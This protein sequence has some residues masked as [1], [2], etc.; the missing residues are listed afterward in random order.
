MSITTKGEKESERRRFRAVCGKRVLVLV[1]IGIVSFCAA[2]LLGQQKVPA[3]ELQVRA[4][5]YVPPSLFS[6][7]TETRL[8]EVGA[9]VRDGRNHSI[10]GLTRDDFEI[11]EGGKKREITAF[12]AEVST[13][14]AAAPGKITPGVAPASAEAAPKSP[15]RFLALLFDDLS[16]KPG[17]L[18]PARKAAR[19]FLAQGISAGDQVSIFALSKGQTLPFTA[20]VQKLEDA[21]DKVNIATRSPILPTCPNLTTYD[22]YVVSERQD[23]SLLPIKVAEARQC[24]FCQPRDTGCPQRVEQECHRIW[25]EVRQMSFNTLASIRSVVDYMAKL[26]GK[27]ILLM[28]SSGFL[29]GTLEAEREEIVNRALRGEVVINSL[30]AKGLY[31]Q[32]MGVSSPGMNSRS[33][34]ARQSQGTRPQFESN[35]T[36]AILS[37]STGG[38]FFQNSN[39]LEAGFRDL[40]LLPEYSYSLA[41]T[42][43]GNPDGKYHRLKVRLRQ[44]HRYDVQA[45]PGYFAAFPVAPEAQV[46]R[47]IDKEV[48]ATDTVNDVAVGITGA[49]VKTTAGESGV[50]IVMRLEIG[51]LP[52]TNLFGARTEQL[53]VIA[54]LFDQAGTF[55]SG[56]ECQ[57]DFNLKDNTFQSLKEGVDAGMTV[58]APPGTYRMRSVVRDGNGGKF[59][60]MTQTVDIR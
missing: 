3:D 59:T 14:P 12:N 32:D 28:A 22:A 27:R 25:G 10:G 37:A 60:A 55:I 11:E 36:M 35:D 18:V 9:V 20:D 4:A 30:D 52:F 53:T 46:E 7:R 5:A 44:N 13:P 16:M 43:A 49:P 23:P 33:T 50:H 24:G 29:S 38:L 8:V 39:D 40:G 26:P 57:L 47:S 51:K 54:A 2:V 17:D 34:I 31:T 1:R 58:T 15:A 41:F 45:R 19:K 56:K 6:V 21:V 48:L 42:P